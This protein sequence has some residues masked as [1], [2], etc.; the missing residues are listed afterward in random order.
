MENVLQ[1]HKVIGQKGQCALAKGTKKSDVAILE[2][3]K[4]LLKKNDITL[5]QSLPKVK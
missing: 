4:A 1:C 5:Y 3:T 2:C